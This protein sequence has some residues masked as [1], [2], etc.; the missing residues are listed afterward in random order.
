MLRFI[1]NIME[2]IFNVCELIFF[3][4]SIIRIFVYFEMQIL[5]KVISRAR[6]TIPIKSLSTKEVIILILVVL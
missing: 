3:T 2:M 6:D 5:Q 1:E 4:D